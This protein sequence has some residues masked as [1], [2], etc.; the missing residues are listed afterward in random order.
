MQAI[1]DLVV[2]T[3]NR[4][5]YL[6]ECLHSIVSQETSFNYNLIVSDNSSNDDTADLL[7]SHW[8]LVSTR[9]FKSIPFD[10]HFKSAIILNTSKYLMIFH[11]DDILLPGYI[12]KAIAKLEECPS[13]SAVSCNAYYYEN[14]VPTKPT[15][16]LGSSNIIANQEMLIKRYLDPW[17][18]GM[19]PFSPYIYRASAL[20]ADFLNLDLAGKYSD[21]LFLLYVL[22]AGPFL[23]LSSPLAYYRIH[24]GSDN[25]EFVF[26][27]KMKMLRSLHLLYGVS[28]SSYQFLNAKAIYYR[29]Y[30][31]VQPNIQSLFYFNAK[32]RRGKVQSFISR[33]TIVRAAQSSQFRK[34]KLWRFSLLVASFFRKQ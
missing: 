30:F 24:P 7:S 8:P 9:R 27:Q 3:R 12:D 33:M 34:D 13:L 29:Q 15:M 2:L 18:G 21:F 19:P 4:P 32:S 16:K 10:V 20:Q 14:Q 6:D 31:G 11:D 1:L 17:A 23:W 26:E 5:R 25:T 22:K 28:K